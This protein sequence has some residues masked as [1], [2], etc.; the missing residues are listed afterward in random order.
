MDYFGYDIS[1][2]IPCEICSKRGTDVHH[3]H[4]RGMGGDPQHKKD[5]IDLLM[6]LCRECHTLFGDKTEYKSFL[7]NMHRN[8]LKLHEIRRKK[9]QR[10]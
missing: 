3:I 4:A 2:F 1:D 10:L 8:T 9:Y 7:I 5:T 6:C